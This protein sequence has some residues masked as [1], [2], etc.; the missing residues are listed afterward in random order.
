MLERYRKVTVDEEYKK[1]PEL[2]KQ[3]VIAIRD[4][5]DEQGDYPEL[6]DSEIILFL[7]SNY[8]NLD[9]TQATIKNYFECR[10][11]Y[12]ELFADFDLEGEALV[13][14]RDTM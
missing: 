11:D 8:Y 5:L 6:S 4:W 10:V 3:D 13:Q 12:K 14:V 7:H 2:K 9:A 1:N